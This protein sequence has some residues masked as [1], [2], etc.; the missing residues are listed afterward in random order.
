MKVTFFRGD[1]LDPQPPVASKQR[2]VRYAHVGE[3][4]EIDE[5]LWREWIRRAA[6]L[7]GEPLF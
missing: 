7:P 2:G 4:D 6:A 1:E 5:D 3:G